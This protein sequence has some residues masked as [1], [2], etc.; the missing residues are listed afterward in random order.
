M[1]NAIV[2]KQSAIAKIIQ[3]AL[4]AKVKANDNAA[5][6]ASAAARE[7]AEE[8][9][10]VNTRRRSLVNSK[11]ST[12]SAVRTKIANTRKQYNTS[13]INSKSV[14]ALLDQANAILS[15]ANTKHVE[16]NT[17]LENASKAD[18]LVANAITELERRYK[19][20][21]SRAGKRVNNLLGGRRTRSKRSTKKRKSTRRQTRRR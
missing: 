4:E 19:S 12:L 6:A 5:A 7:A 11:Q 21:S 10:R 8:S 15:T 20:I 1:K 18:A 14:P 13:G 17:Y 9:A 3:E 16:D 2:A